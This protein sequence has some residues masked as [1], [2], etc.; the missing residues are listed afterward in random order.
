M[1]TFNLST[2]FSQQDLERFYATGTNV[3]VAKPNGGGLPN[4]AWVVYRPLLT[5]KVV[6]EE[7]Y[8][9]YA[10]NTDLTNGAVI[11]QISATPVPALENKLYVITPSGYFGP[12]ASG[13][14]PESYSVEND[15]NNLPKGYLTVGLCQNATV[16]GAP[17]GANA[18]S[19]APVLFQST[20]VITPFTTVYLWTQ[21][22]V[23]S[24]SVVTRVTSQMT[25]V[26]FGG[27][28]TEIGL[29]YD[30]ETGKFIPTA[31]G[32]VQGISIHHPVLAL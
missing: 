20:A 27:N 6:W 2:E 10:S 28:V 21:S 26:V 3:V 29:R 13:G 22:S 17:S 19:A 7:E 32:G 5:N 4:V 23:V 31:K 1:P 24:N 14:T 15:Y 12:P 9:I 16:N 25:K 18:V 8:G 11:T 30:S